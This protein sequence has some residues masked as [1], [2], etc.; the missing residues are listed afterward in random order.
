MALNDEGNVRRRLS[1]YARPV[2]HRAVDKLETSRLLKHEVAYQRK[3][4]DLLKL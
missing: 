4:S 1:D 2:L 3:F